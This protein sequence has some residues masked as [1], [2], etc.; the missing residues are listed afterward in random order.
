MINTD[1]LAQRTNLVF[2]ILNTITLANHQFDTGD[3]RLAASPATGQQL[4][5]THQI[6]ID[7]SNGQHHD[8]FSLLAN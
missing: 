1:L 6:F 3:K 8:D 2:Q 7:V 4:G 5:L